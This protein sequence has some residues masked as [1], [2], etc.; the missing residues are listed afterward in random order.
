MTQHN[1]VLTAPWGIY[2][3][4]ISK[5]DVTVPILGDLSSLCQIG[6]A[7]RVY[8]KY[9]NSWNWRNGFLRKEKAVKGKHE[10]YDEIK[11]TAE[12]NLYFL[13]ELLYIYN[14]Q[15]TFIYEGG[16]ELM[17]AFFTFKKKIQEYSKEIKKY[18]PKGITWEFIEDALNNVKKIAD[19]FNPKTDI[20]SNHET[21]V[22]QVI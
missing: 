18:Q 14:A 15:R 16:D 19:E 2:L 13:L 5:H 1:A 22:L 9:R 4:Y 3:F 11:P 20:F 10:R 12:F 8:E 21:L 17:K 7:C 6:E